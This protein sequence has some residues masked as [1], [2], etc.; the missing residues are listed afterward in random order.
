MYERHTASKQWED[1]EV[2]LSRF[3]GQTVRLQL[4]CHPGPREDTTCDQ[5]FWA[6]PTLLVG[7]AQKQKETGRAARC[8][9]PRA[10]ALWKTHK[11]RYDVVLWPGQRGLLDATVGFL[12]GP[13]RLLFQGFRVQVL[14]I[15]L[16]DVNSPVVLRKVV[17]ESAADV[18]R[19]RHCFQSWAGNFDLLGELQAR[20]GTLQVRFWLENAP[21][22]QPWRA[23]YLEGVSLGPWNQAAL[24]VYAGAGN[25]L[26]QPE[27]FRLNFDGHRL[28]TSFVGFDFA[29]GF[30]LVQAVDVPPDYLEVDPESRQYTLRTP[31]PQTMTLIPS[32]DVWSAVSRWRAVNGLRPAGGVN[33]L[34]GRFVF[35]LWGG[36]YGESA[37]A[38]QRAFRY[39]LTDAVVVWHNWQ[40]WGYDYRLPDICPAQFRPGDGGRVPA[41][42][43]KC[44]G[45][46]VCCSLRTTTTSISIPMPTAT[47]TS[48]SR[49]R[50]RG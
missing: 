47:R 28:A 43:R 49:L 27:A 36:R 34:A 23:V 12:D 9:R 32:P 8:R 44:A 24:R 46:R 4:E 14:G 37:A 16:E 18:G 13:R 20:E 7:E 6:E 45:N 15:P 11:V 30:S 50:P 17:D 40:R 10:L 48:K 38:L 35:D 5:A 26:E 41:V 3:A 42:W 2:D 21:P 33:K 19:W 31:H 25:V 29:G 1:A 22:P 39:G